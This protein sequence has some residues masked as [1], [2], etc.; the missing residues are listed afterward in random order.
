[1]GQVIESPKR[2][3]VSGNAV[4]GKVGK[5]TP[6]RRKA[7]RESRTREYLTPSEIESLLD[8][9]TTGRYGH[10]D[11]TLLLIMYRHGLRVGEAINLRWEQIDLK[12]G[13]FAV[14]R[15]KQGVPSTHPLRGSELLALRQLRREWPDGPYLFV[16]ERGGPMTA[17]NVRKVVTRSGL[18]AKLPFPIHP[19]M[20][21][22]ACG[23]KLA[24]EGHDTRSL[25]HYL[26]HK[27]IA[28]TVRYTEMPPD[29]FKSFW[30][31]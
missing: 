3:R 6:P 4:K 28:H 1:M 15:L 26:G 19:H 11:R 18:V 5:V 13:L 24:N 16:S 14:R 31:D 20:L 22:H 29:R 30:K 8:A 23:Y 21:R 25:Q 12:A 10:R 27:N 17:S 2:R 7:N 9:T